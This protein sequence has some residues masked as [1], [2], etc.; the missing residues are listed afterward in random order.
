MVFPRNLKRLPRA[1]YMGQRQ[2]FLT[3]LTKSRRPYFREASMVRCCRTQILRAGN[4]TGFADIASVYMPDHLHMVIEGTRAESDMWVFVKLAKQLSAY[5]AKVE[6]G[7]RV[8]EKGLH[9]RIIREA[10]DLGR[11]IEY[12]RENPVK[13]GLARTPEEYPFLF[14]RRCGRDL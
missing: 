3:F 1:C 4:K 5:E 8:W 10:E 13:A 7:I 9:D 12:I 14:G 11:Y 6:F 2:Y